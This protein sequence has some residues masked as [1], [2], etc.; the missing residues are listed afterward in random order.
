MTED[1]DEAA[2]F[3]NRL[4]D[5]LTKEGVLRSPEWDSAVRAV[6]RAAFLAGGWF[7]YE[8]G[9]WWRPTSITDGPD[10]LGR[11][12]ENDTLV[13]QVGGVVVPRQVDGRVMLAPTSSSTL[14]SL[15]VRM[16]EELR[17]TDGARVLEVG[18]GT[19]YSTAL[20]THRLGD[21]RVTSVEVDRDVSASAGVALA[22]LDLW[23]TLIVGDGLAGHI[24][25]APYDRVIATCGVT[26]VPDEWIAQTRPGGE[27][28][29][30][31]YGGW[32]GASEL[33]RLTVAEDGTAEG[34]MLG[35]RVGFMM[36][37]PQT[38][39]PLGLL[40]DLDSADEQPTDLGAD[41]LTDWTTRWVAGFAVPTVQRL[42]LSRDGNPLHVLVDV[43]A[44]S[45]ASV[46]QRNGRW[47]ARQGGGARL[48]DTIT[49][50][51]TEWRTAELPAE[52]LRVR[53]GPEGQRLTWE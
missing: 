12:Y 46:Y 21:D 30:P 33:V 3:R 16:C 36:A 14:P 44:G 11:A 17:V 40:P 6:P 31:I 25:G 2:R 52:S 24:P 39:P 37:R 49:D 22:G 8:D 47:F 1:Q 32:M 15:V 19:G 53:V 35:G 20:L 5:R 27:I 23:P 29:A 18:T 45:W 7:E 42:M 50:R 26:T 9:G 48:W 28:L 13:T 4:A 10:K 38:P 43:E 34:P 41:A 51:V